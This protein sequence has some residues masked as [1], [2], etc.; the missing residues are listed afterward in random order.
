M[1]HHFSA[2]FRGSRHRHAPEVPPGLPSDPLERRPDFRQAEAQLIAA[3]AQ[4]GVAKAAYFP[5]ISLTASGGFQ[6]SALTRP[7]RKA[8]AFRPGI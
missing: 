1:E 2:V 6:S 3:N 4:I 7:S 8:S 5:Q